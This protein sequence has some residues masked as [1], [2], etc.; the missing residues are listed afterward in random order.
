[1]RKIF[2]RYFDETLELNSDGF[3]HIV[4]EKKKTYRE[5]LLELMDQIN[6]EGE[7]LVLKNNDKEIELSKSAI[8]IKNPVFWEIDE[9]KVST[10]VQKDIVMSLCEERI[11]EYKK[12]LADI[13]RWINAICLDYSLPI[14][15]DAELSVSS[16]L[17]AFSVSSPSQS[18]GFLEQFISNIKRMASIFKKDL[19][20]VVNAYDVFDEKEIETIFQ[21]M[22]R[23]EINVIFVSAHK[24]NSYSS[25]EKMIY[26]DCDLAELHLH[27][28]DLR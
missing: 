14:S 20:F 13:N 8:L 9:K 17:K 16:F 22:K 1:M 3:Y 26:I 21:E 28:S 4:I 24:P 5:F 15:Y 18:E 6:G 11:S 2:S 12:L 27:R 10:L 19:F 23:N 25:S 7:C